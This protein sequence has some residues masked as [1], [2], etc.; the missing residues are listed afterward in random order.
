MKK[1]ALSRFFLFLPFLT[2]A[3]AV[4]SEARSELRALISRRS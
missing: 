1:P 3:L 2:A 4:R